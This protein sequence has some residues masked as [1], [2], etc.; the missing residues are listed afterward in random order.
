MTTLSRAGAKGT[1]VVGS[2]LGAK[3]RNDGRT[4]LHLVN[5]AAGARTV[6]VVSAQ[7]VIGLAVADLAVVVPLSSWIPVGLFPPD[8]FN[9]PI[10]AGMVYIDFPAGTESD[11]TVWAFRP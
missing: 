6:T 5:G 3:F 7:E 8:T 11:I 2:A 4:W 9:Q 10:E 1:G